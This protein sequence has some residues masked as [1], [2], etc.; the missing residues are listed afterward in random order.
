MY[1]CQTNYQIILTAG[2]KIG[3]LMQS[4]NVS[5]MKATKMKTHVIIGSY[6]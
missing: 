3:L 6:F 2:M 4:N 5:Y 1:F